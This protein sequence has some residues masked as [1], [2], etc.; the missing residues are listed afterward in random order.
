ME[1]IGEYTFTSGD[2]YKGQI[3][4]GQFG[5]WGEFWYRNGDHYDGEWKD[6]KR[7]GQGTFTHANGDVY[8]GS[9]VA[10]E[11]EGIGNFLRYDLFG[12]NLY[13]IMKCA[14]IRCVEFM[15]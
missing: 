6:Y 12:A 3:H 9:W 14:H 10:G 4:D 2:R 15:P 13:V 8:T 11:I 1:G 5:P 7:H